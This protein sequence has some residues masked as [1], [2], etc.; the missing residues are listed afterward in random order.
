MGENMA[1]RREKLNFAL[2]RFKGFLSIFRKSKR[3]MI[4]VVIIVLFALLAILAPVL[5]PNAPI[6]PMWKAGEFPAMYN[7]GPQIAADMCT[8]YWYK[9]LPWVA[10]GSLDLQEEF[11]TNVTEAGG[12]T[13][14]L[15]GHQGQPAVDTSILLA[16]RAV[17][18]PQI[19]V[20]FPNDTSRML[21][22][23]EE[24]YW[25]CRDPLAVEFPDTFLF[26]IGTN[27]TVTYTSGRDVTENIEPVADVHLHSNQTSQEK[28]NWNT[29]LD[30]IAVKYNDH[31]GTEN[32]G[33]IE[34]GYDPQ[35][36]DDPS[37]GTRA[38][39]WTQFAY[40]Y[41]EPPRAFWGYASTLVAGDPTAS[42]NI[43]VGFYRE[44]GEEFFPVATYNK[45][46]ALGYSE[47]IVMSTSTEVSTIVGAQNPT[48]AIFPKPA[49]YS[50]AFEITFS[51]N[52]KTSVYL[53]NLG[54]I[55]YGNAFGLLGTDNDLA[56]PRDLFSTLA[57][58]TRVSLTVGVLTAVFSTLIGLFL[59]L[60]AGYM[61]GLADEAIMRTADL[62]L[63]I[64]TLPLFI[65]LVVALS[66]VTRGLVSIWNI[67]LVLTL[68]GW[69]G[70]ARTVRSMVLSL[71]ERTFIEAAR[72]SGAS[73][74]YIINRHVL[75]NVFALVYITLATAVPGAI[76]TEASLSWLGLGDPRI[77]S[78]GK[79]LYDFQSSGV[80]ITR[81]L[82][83][84]WYWMFPACISIAL[85]ATAFILMGFALDEIL[86]PRLRQ[87]R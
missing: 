49:N 19:E 87:R 82:T 16:K 1:T 60:V 6:N 2:A 12:R 80:V 83:D 27:L 45:T 64:P 13:F 69:M 25:N 62:F 75:P 74:F 57:Y 10:R 31:N 63:V 54:W 43:T 46:V 59:G 29:T 32:D 42:V 23:S 21:A 70:F 35:A 11:Y 55:L 40:P 4:G 15:F 28:W 79:I 20:T 44:G 34:I 14:Q 71:R 52:A 67:I 50:L 39:V 81:G 24:W 36:S 3:G 7:R 56:F 18:L 66:M 53:D 51:G 8:P 58:G 76:V 47:N 5:T 48:R 41:W 85:L 73:S 68:F 9:Y 17:Q 61:G 84:Y 22:P 33:C 78:W 30:S 37:K 72:A 77:A 86:N 65:I 38:F 26:P